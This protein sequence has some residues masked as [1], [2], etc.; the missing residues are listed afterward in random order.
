MPHEHG[1][2]WHHRRRRR[3]R[4]HEE[5]RL[6][7][8]LAGNPNV[9]KTSLFN[10]LTG[11]RQHVGNW[12]G[13]TVEK[14]V[15]TRHHAGHR[16]EVV[17]LPG[18][19]SLTA[20][21]IDEIVARDY[22]IDEKPD[23]VV[24]VVDATNLDRNL[25]LTTQLMTTGCRLVMALN[26]FDVSEA[27]GDCI[28]LQKMEEFLE[29]PVVPT[30]AADGTGIQR[31]L[32]EIVEEA[33]REAHHHHMVGYGDDLET[34]ISLLV[35]TMDDDPEL[36]A[37]YPLR[38]MA[39]KLL[40]GDENV[41][42]RLSGSPVE[43]RV[44]EMLREEDAELV[45]VEMAER[46]YQVID[47]ILGQALVRCQLEVTPSDYIDR[48]LTHK[49][50]GI[51]I[52]LAMMWGAFTLTFTV[53]V[54]F[55][56]IIDT[57]FAELGGWITSNVSPD[58]LASL[59]ADGIIGGVG[60][61]LVF[62]PPIF[63]LFLLLAILEDSGYLARAAFNM[64]RVMAKVG[65]HGKSFIPMLMGFG[66]NVPAIL[67]TRSIEDRRDRFITILVNPFMSCGAR[68]PVFV[69]LAGAFFGAAAGTAI[70][71]IYVLG[72]LVAVV[73]AKLLRRTLLRGEPAPFIMEMPRYQ[74]PSA[75][76]VLTHTWE[77]TWMYVRKAG[78][79][80][81]AGAMIVWLMASLPW[82]VEYG[83]A[84]SVAGVLGKAMEPLVAPLGFDWRIVVALI[85]GFVAK[86]LV[87]G[88]MGVLYSGGGD[89]QSLV[90][91]LTD[92]GSGLNPA[93]AAGLMAFTLLYTPCLATIG[94][95]WK[96]TGSLR[97]TAVSIAYSMAIAWLVAFMIYRAGLALGWG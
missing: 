76:L 62:V 71:G 17:D 64:D 44:V 97:W 85:F 31:L 81:L 54:P 91:R 2:H 19:Y 92:P 14:K 86:E 93:N 24:H 38:W 1:G 29:V 39:V 16:L 50:L 67:S 96:E 13:V 40:E 9:G 47:T 72:I 18:T 3:E 51:P 95:I 32:D 73:T 56:A 88:T 36:A 80:I 61:V 77:R 89:G 53:S 46:R 7:I 12:P 43:G 20:N 83:S 5:H 68:L 6:R 42:E 75:G 69:L 82:G 55:S 52:F 22:I 78:T 45:E 63:V 10:A 33:D 74:V 84:D 11:A 35:E 8:A 65:L 70:F 21:S 59:L 48:V 30:S 23:V 25:Y 58:W 41:L 49:W 66:C 87:A 28:D 94:A 90:D 34:R 27:R 57:A 15:G 26:M 79:V 60:F 37:R 4:P